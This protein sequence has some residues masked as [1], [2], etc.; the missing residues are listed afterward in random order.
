M[1]APP[2]PDSAYV[3]IPT[4]NEL[5]STAVGRNHEIEAEFHQAR[6]AYLLPGGRMLLYP[7]TPGATSATLVS[8]HVAWKEWSK[9][10]DDPDNVASSWENFDWVGSRGQRGTDDTHSA[11]VI[12]ARFDDVREVLRT[13]FRTTYIEDALNRDVHLR[14]GSAIVYALADQPFTHFVDSGVS[15]NT[16]Q[17]A[18]GLSI[19]LETDVVWASTC[20]R[21]GWA[22]HRAWRSGECI[23]EF[24]AEEGDGERPSVRSYLWSCRHVQAVE[25]NPDIYAF[26][27]RFLR[28]IDLFEPGL[29]L[30][31]FI[32][33]PRRE[34]RT[35]ALVRV[36]NPS[37]EILVTPRRTASSRPPIAALDYL[38]FP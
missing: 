32:R 10:N 9:Y 24:Y 19:A 20:V 11:L 29:T 38:T 31:D 7:S 18:E 8:S 34:R 3:S 15:D 30:E 28:E 1:S 27:D 14:P 13:R 17:L 25:W 6:L 22:A 23:E 33:Q 2:F 21:Q 26:T 12:R 37:L 4:A 35:D 5:I 36:E 16:V